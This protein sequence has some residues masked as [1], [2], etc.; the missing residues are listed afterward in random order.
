MQLKSEL[1]SEDDILNSEISVNTRL[2][3]IKF[4]VATSHAQWATVL[5]QGLA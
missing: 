1:D 4:D 2:R 3:N 5:Q